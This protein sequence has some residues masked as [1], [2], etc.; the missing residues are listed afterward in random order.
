MIVLV[1]V[2]KKQRNSIPSNIICVERTNSP[3]EL[4]EIYSSAF[5]FINASQEETMG[6]TTVEAMACGTPVIVTNKTAVPEV[7]NHYGGY[8]LDDFTPNSVISIM[9][10]I[11]RKALT[12][13]VNALDYEMNAQYQKYM[14]LYVN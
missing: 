4:A 1:G 2:S 5:V 10:Q 6:L 13:R 3:K 7:V 12:P 8:V 11:D 14:Q 9:N